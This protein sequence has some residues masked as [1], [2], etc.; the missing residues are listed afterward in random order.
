MHKQQWLIAMQGINYLFNDFSIS[1][2]DRIIVLTEIRDYY[3]N[4]ISNKSS[5]NKQILSFFSLNKENIESNMIQSNFEANYFFYFKERSDKNALMISELRK[6]S[7]DYDIVNYIHM[8][9]NRLFESNQNQKEVIIYDLLIR[10]YKS[11][12]FRNN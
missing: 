12:L 9:I 5:V 4:A 2:K 6:N 1:L 8:F 3:Y 11:L 7:I 10:Y